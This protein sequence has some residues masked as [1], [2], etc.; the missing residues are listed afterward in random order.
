M[1]Q[2]ILNSGT[3]PLEPTGAIVLRDRT[4]SEATS[5]G[6]GSFQGG[7]PPFFYIDAGLVVLG[8]SVFNIHTLDRV[9]LPPNRAFGWPVDDDNWL[10]V[11]SP[12]GDFSLFNHP[13]ATQTILF[14]RN[15]VALWRHPTTMDILDVRGCCYNVSRT[16]EGPLWRVPYNMATEPPQLLA[17]RATRYVRRLAAGHLATIIDIDDRGF[18]TLTWVDPDTQLGIPIADHVYAP[19]FHA[20][21]AVADDVVV[22]SVADGPDSG[23]YLTRLPSLPQ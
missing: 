7:S 8:S 5:L 4:T 18:G 11:P 16:D 10:L 3:D 2:S 15:A 12:Y 20:L 14:S 21:R 13:E 22:V 17:Q 9:A 6:D 19:S 1:W 23:V